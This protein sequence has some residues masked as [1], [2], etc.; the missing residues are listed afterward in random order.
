MAAFRGLL[1]F[2]HCYLIASVAA[3]TL[4]DF[5]AFG[6]GTNDR[7]YTAV[8]DGSSPPVTLQEFFPFFDDNQGTVYVSN[9]QWCIVCIKIVQNYE[10]P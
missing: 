8:D 3:I 4:E 6:S 1:I 10:E 2:Y 5:Y 9:F 7:N